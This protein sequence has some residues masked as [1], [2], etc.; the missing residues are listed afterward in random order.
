[1]LVPVEEEEEEEE[2]EGEAIFTMLERTHTGKSS[3]ATYAADMLKLSP[4]LRSIRVFNGYMIPLE[5]AS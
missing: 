3:I 4:G 5:T 2:E 1:M